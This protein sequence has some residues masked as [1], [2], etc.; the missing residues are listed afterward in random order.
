MKKKLLFLS[1]FA[2]LAALFAIGASASAYTY[3][4]G[5]TEKIDF[6]ENDSAY[7][8]TVMG[9]PQA[10]SKDAR[11]V[12]SCTCEKGV[13]TYPTYYIMQEKKS[14]WLDLFRRDFANLNANN[15]CGA[16]Y[17]K[18]SILAIEV[19]EGIA[20]FWGQQNTSGVFMNHTS[21]V[22]VSLPSTMEDLHQN[23]FRGCTSLEWV[24]FSK[25]TK[26]K[27]LY[28]S[29]FN[30]CT[31]LKGVCLPD[32]ITTM[33]NATFIGCV[34]LGPV[35]LPENLISFGTDTQW[36]T[37][38]SGA[39]GEGSKFTK[40]FLTNEKF[41]NPDEVVKPE[42]YYMP[43]NFKKCGDQLFRGCSNINYVIVFPTT[44]TAVGDSRSFL[45]YGATAENP[46]TI[47]FL[48]DM[49]SFSAYA[50]STSSY[51]NYVF[52]NANDTADGFTYSFT[53]NGASNVTIYSCASQKVCTPTLD[54]W[55]SQGFAHFA[56]PKTFELITQSTCTDNQTV[57][58]S[59]Y[60][61]ASMGAIEV[62]NTAL[63]H[64]HIIDAGIVYEDY[65]KAGYYALLCERCDDIKQ[66]E[67]TEALFTC[68]GFSAALYG[69]GEMSVNYKVNAQ[70]ISDYEEITG[71]KVNYGVFAVRADK[72]GT[73]DIF[74]AEGNSPAGVIA[75]DITDSGFTFFSLKI[76]GFTETQKGIDFAMGAFV[77][78]TKDA[79]TEYAYLQIAAP[80]N[81][82]KYFFA[83]YNDVKAIVDAKNGVSAQ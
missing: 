28:N 6:F 74:D 55:T 81:G 42:V 24:D 35:Y 7:I 45:D 13:H 16:T 64:N 10:E 65:T 12:L 25:T 20:D 78:T 19:P 67:A 49:T 14:D 59:C 3:D 37:F 53:S 68:L 70:A 29:S 21:L 34:N 4:F 33:Q 82:E 83:S 77:G 38:V 79:K 41:D 1:I 80:E 56:N 52:A 23:P 27:T 2:I 57:S 48:G 60:C 75:A 36:N 73:N 11:V 54:A 17:T 51:M 31:S 71:K 40:L 22:Y 46:K 8:N 76:N 15:P 63:G 58:A 30:G 39:N 47:V 5:E 9:Y 62:E 69:E 43:S 18:D 66:G 50:D 72:I 26:I 61:G 32:S 44:Y